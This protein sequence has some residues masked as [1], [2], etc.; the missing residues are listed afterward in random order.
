MS[1]FIIQSIRYTMEV[2]SAASRTKIYAECV[3]LK[4]QHRDGHPRLLL[5]CMPAQTRWQQ[6]QLSQSYEIPRQ[7][8]SSK[9]VAT[10][11]FT[12]LRSFVSM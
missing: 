10:Y 9:L 11:T 6:R 3:Q 12:S 8:T 1:S 5:Q 2:N 7:E 4:I